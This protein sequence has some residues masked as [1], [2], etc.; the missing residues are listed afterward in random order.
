MITFLLALALFFPACSGDDADNNAT[1]PVLSSITPDSAVSNSESFTLTANGSNFETGAAI[2][3]NGA[4][5]NTTF[6]SSN[7]LT[8]TVTTTDTIPDASDTAEADTN[9]E[10]YVRNPGD[11]DS[12]ALSFTITDTHLFETPRSIDVTDYNLFAPELVI[13]TNGTLYAALWDSTGYYLSEST[14]SGENWTEKSRIFD[15]TQKLVLDI[16]VNNNLYALYASDKIQ[17]KRSTNSGR[18]W[19][20]ALTLA[21]SVNTLGHI[22]LANLGN[23]VLLAT[24]WNVDKTLYYARSGDN[25]LTWTAPAVF[26]TKIV[27]HS[28]TA[29]SNGNFYIMFTRGGTVY[30]RKSSNN[31]GS[32]GSQVEIA[33]TT[34]RRIISDGTNVYVLTVAGTNGISVYRST[35][36]GATWSEPGFT[37]DNFSALRLP[38][39]A[40]DSRGNIN[41][42][43]TA[44]LVATGAWESVHNGILTFRS[45]DNNSTWKGGSQISDITG[46]YGFP[47]PDAVIDSSGR[48]YLVW[49]VSEEDADTEP[50]SSTIYF[51]RST[52]ED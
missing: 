41:L 35:D 39:L 2:Y 45:I 27:T 32:W 5:K 33:N 36:A 49:S 6:V 29:D 37:R 47:G 25:G 44:G 46:Q 18:T 50:S 8:C 14:D 40:A 42:F 38:A 20:D 24:W 15:V 34:G 31:A 23:G 10:V 30:V 43:G 3:F 52:L 16:G 21:T 51:T 17:F 48:M 11:T 22:G 26:G 12:S 1:P 9:I 19:T 13:S 28:V 7:E 4:A